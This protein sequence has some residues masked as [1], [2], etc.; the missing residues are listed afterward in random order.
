MDYILVGAIFIEKNIIKEDQYISITR[1][2][3]GEWVYFNGNSIKTCTFNELY[4]HRQLK[5]LFYLGEEKH[6]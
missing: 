5:M 4:N 2:D 6:I 3:N 1:K